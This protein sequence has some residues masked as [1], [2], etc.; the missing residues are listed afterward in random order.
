MINELILP[1]NLS[2]SICYSIQH[3]VVK[4]NPQFQE[5]KLF[6][7]VNGKLKKVEDYAKNLFKVAGWDVY[8]GDDVHLFLSVLSCNFQNSFFNDVIK[9]YV[10]KNAEKYINELELIIQDSFN[11]G[12]IQPDL[13]EKASLIL[14]KYYNTYTPKKKIMISI[15][16]CIKNIDQNILFKLLK[17]YREDGYSTKGAPDLFI[18]SNNIFYF[19]EVKSQTDSLS[20]FQYHYFEKYLTLVSDNIFVLRIVNH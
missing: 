13:V 12:I 7:Y 4:A 17:L 15:A 1:K 18:Y 5:K 3:V 9:N 19:V 16:D 6:F 2:E 14:Q 10:G 11:D 8:K 20:Q